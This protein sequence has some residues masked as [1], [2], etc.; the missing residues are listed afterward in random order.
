MSVNE[1]RR[2]IKGCL[3]SVYE[4]VVKIQMKLSKRK[5]IVIKVICILLGLFLIGVLMVL[6]IN[7]YVKGSVEDKIMSV[8]DSA[9]LDGLDCII[10]LGCKVKDDKSPSDMLKDRMKRA[11]ELY[12]KGVAPKIL[13]SGDHGRTN[14]NEV[15]TM[16][17]YAIDK[18]VPSEDIF[19]DHAGFSTY[20]TMY[21]AKEVFGVEKAIVVTQDYH[22]YRS[23]YI[24]NELGID[25]Y[26]CPSA[27]Y[28][29]YGQTSRDIR[30]VVARCKDFVT[31][32]FKPEP[33]YLGDAIDIG[34][35]GDVTNDY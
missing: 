30:E 28:N 7:A 13:M 8:E 33:T 29:Y 27:R 25:A 24:A 12:E 11:I 23:L 3:K 34:G 16:K 31:T 15:M 32:I 10:V 26:G 14:Y 2:T 18:G 20:E 6:G 9:K 22:M 35:S 19:M 21:R 5:K 4:K 1:Q 17:Q